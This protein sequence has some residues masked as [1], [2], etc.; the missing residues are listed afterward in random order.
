MFNLS[1]RA[2]GNH[3]ESRP[4]LTQQAL[5]IFG[6]FWHDA[7]ANTSPVVGSG[8]RVGAAVC[9]NHSQQRLANAVSSSNVLTITGYRARAATYT[10]PHIRVAPFEIIMLQDDKA[11]SSGGGG[12][13]GSSKD[14]CCSPVP[15]LPKKCQIAASLFHASRTPHLTA[16]SNN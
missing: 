1:A 12:S 6:Y 7:Y 4:H 2:R 10:Q 5:F 14:R 15:G 8:N 9:V 3:L 16:E 11:S 13:N